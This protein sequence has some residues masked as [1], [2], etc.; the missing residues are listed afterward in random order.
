MWTQ[1]PAECHLKRIR[2]TFLL[3][4]GD[5]FVCSSLWRLRGNPLAH[6]PQS[7][8]HGSHYQ[9]KLCLESLSGEGMSKM[10]FISSAHKHK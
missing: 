8:P 5:F 7:T 4:V 1:G 9:Q 2:F 3:R 6:H 10:R